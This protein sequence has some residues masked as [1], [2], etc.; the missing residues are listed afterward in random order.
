M[1]DHDGELGFMAFLFLLPVPVSHRISSHRYRNL[2][3][4]ASWRG[5]I[6]GSC[7]SPLTQRPLSRRRSFVS[8]SFMYHVSR[9]RK[10]RERLAI[11]DRPEGIHSLSFG[12]SLAEA[13]SNGANP[14]LGFLQ[15][16]VEM[17]APRSWCLRYDGCVTTRGLHSCWNGMAADRVQTLESF[18][19]RRLKLSSPMCKT[20]H[21]PTLRQSWTNTSRST[22][23]G[24]PLVD[25]IANVMFAQMKSF[26]SGTENPHLCG[27]EM[28][29]GGICRCN[30]LAVLPDLYTNCSFENGHF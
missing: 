27:W 22:A 10:K 18:N 3:S 29:S 9:R 5:P 8:F 19:T 23:D 30:V 28:R 24:V 1:A 20:R 17:F 25:E 26:G 2:I 11:A 16:S 14:S 15:D 12:D 7:P 21:G 6:S 4:P 13:S